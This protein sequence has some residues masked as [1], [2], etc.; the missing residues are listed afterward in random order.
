[1][2]S[3][4]VTSG[5]LWKFAER[6][7]AQ[8]VSFI[9]SLVLARLLMPEDYGVVALIL[10]FIEIANVFVT[11]GLGAALIQKKDCDQLD[12]SSAFYFNFLTSSILYLAL[13]FFSPL[14][15]SLYSNDLL[16]PVIRVFGIRI[17]FASF[18]SI[19]HAYVS[20]NMLFKKFFWSTLS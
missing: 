18:N 7:S 6:F 17:I 13:F 5:F 10:V 9:V 15:S 12:F 14:I 4:G 11:A 2:S 3:N 8:I 16:T 19:Q 20:K 1:M